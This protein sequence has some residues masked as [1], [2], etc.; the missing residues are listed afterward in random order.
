MAIAEL[1]GG[2]QRATAQSYSQDTSLAFPSNVTAGNLIVIAGGGGGDSAPAITVT[3]DSGSTATLGTIQ[4]FYGPTGTNV[5]APYIAFAVV[6]TSGTLTMHVVTDN[7]TSNYVDVYCTEFTGSGFALDVDG[8]EYVET[9]F[10]IPLVDSIT[11]LTANALILAAVVPPGSVVSWTAGSGYTLF[12]SDSSNAF[13]P[14]A[15][16]YKIAGAAG[17]YTVDMN[18]GAGS[19]ASIYDLAIKEGVSIVPKSMHARRMRS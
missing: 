2:T 7:V 16:E 1:G 9:G 19:Q 10:P 5:S 4:T 6:L 8:G 15:V 17:S 13:Q 12:G 18:L 14:S 11:T 3:R